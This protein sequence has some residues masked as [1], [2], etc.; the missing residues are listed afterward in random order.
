MLLSRLL[1]M[2]VPVPSQSLSHAALTAADGSIIGAVAVIVA[3]RMLL[4]PPLLMAVSQCRRSHRRMLLS[5]LLMA[6]SVPS[7]SLSHCMLLSPL[8][9]A[10]SVPSQ[11]S[12]HVPCCSHY[13]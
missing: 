13:C 8:L 7:Q 5:P 1:L 3:C 12:S 10:V 2:A 9:M 6:V 11:S 4:S